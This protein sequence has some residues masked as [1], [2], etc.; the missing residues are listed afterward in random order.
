VFGTPGGSRIISMVLLGVL[1]YLDHPQRD[2]ARVIGAPRFHHQYLPDRVLTEPEP[3]AMPKEWIEALRAKGH[4]VEQ[5]GRAWGNMQG[6][7]VDKRDG[8]ATP[9]SDPRGKA[10]MLF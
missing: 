10:G 8:A 9:H 3:Y 5:A 7:Y 1:E 6:V 2:L 4:T